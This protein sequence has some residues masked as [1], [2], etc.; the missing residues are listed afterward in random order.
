MYVHRRYRTLEECNFV[1]KPTNHERQWHRKVQEGSTVTRR[2]NKS[3]RDEWEAERNQQLLGAM[4]M[5]YQDLLKHIL[6]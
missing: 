6:S 4:T 2:A 1:L 5:L 3:F